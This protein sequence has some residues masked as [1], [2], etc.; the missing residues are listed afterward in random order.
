MNLFS[1]EMFENTV[2]VMAKHTDGSVPDTP[3]KWMDEFGTFSICQV[4]PKLIGLW[5]LNVKTGAEAKNFAQQTSQ[6]QHCC[7]CLNMCG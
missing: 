7:F 2:Y 5:G 1:L 4:P 3:E 6:W